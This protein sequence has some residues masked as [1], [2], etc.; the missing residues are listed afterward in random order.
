MERLPH[1]KKWKPQSKSAKEKSQ[2]KDLYST[3]ATNVTTKMTP[4]VKI[5][6]EPEEVQKNHYADLDNSSDDGSAIMVQATNSKQVNGITVIEVKGKEGTCHATT[7]LIDNGF[8]GNAIMSYPFAEKLGYE[9]QQSKGNHSI[10][11]QKHEHIA[12]CDSH[13]CSSST[14]K[15]SENIH[16]NI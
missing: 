5:N 4:M 6:K 16:S 11:R 8:T 12:F 13:K 3:K 1:N 2:K 14:F 7:I 9:F 10:Q 15:S